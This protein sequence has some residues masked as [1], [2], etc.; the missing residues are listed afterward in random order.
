M[1]LLHDW[2]W[3]AALAVFALFTAL[4]VFWPLPEKKPAPTPAPAPPPSPDGPAAEIQPLVW[5]PPASGGQDLLRYTVQE[6]DT[7]QE[8]ARL[9]V[10]LRGDLLEANHEDGSQPPAPGRTIWIPA[11]D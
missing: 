8:I 1:K 2:K 7:W 3:K 6:G 11:A 5:P 4:V 9:F 10:V